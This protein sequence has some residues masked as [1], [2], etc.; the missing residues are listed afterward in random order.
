MKD[1]VEVFFEGKKLASFQSGESI[2]INTN[3]LVRYV[4][5]VVSIT[6]NNGK[7]MWFKVT[8][9]GDNYLTGFDI[10]RMNRTVMMEEV[11]KIDMQRRNKNV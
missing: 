8:G 9:C 7:E 4:G 1:N 3:P 11:K 6:F 10:E 5:E 2:E